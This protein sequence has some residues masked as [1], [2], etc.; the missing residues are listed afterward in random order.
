M[1]KFTK[2][3]L[4]LAGIFTFIGLVCVM[5]SITLGL[6]WG[7]FSDMVKRGRFNIVFDNDIS[8]GGK[9]EDT[10]QNLDNVQDL[11]VD[12]GAGKLEIYY[13]DVEEIQVQQKNVKGFACY[14]EDGTLYIEGNNGNLWRNKSNSEIVVRIPKDTVF[15]EVDMEIGAGQADVR[16]LTA[17]SVDVEAGAGEARLTGLRI[18]EIDAKVGAGK[19]YLELVD[20]E[21]DYSYDAECGI[22]EI[23]VGKTSIG[24]LG[25]SKSVENPGAARHM[26][27]ECGVGQIQVEFQK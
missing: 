26:D 5:V 8:F 20:S 23:K 2:I 27:L 3:A 25:G 11:D 4:V 17:D 7:K 19:L 22:G 6:T 18:K 12:F 24:G 9:T 10:T 16:D 14:V 1:K 21:K 15:H 13:A